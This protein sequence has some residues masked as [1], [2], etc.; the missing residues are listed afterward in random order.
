MCSCS[1]P[2]FRM[3]HARPLDACSCSP[4]C[5]CRPL[6]LPPPRRDGVSWSLR[7]VRPSGRLSHS[8]NSSRCDHGAALIAHHLLTCIREDSQMFSRLS[9]LH[10]NQITARHLAVASVFTILAIA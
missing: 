4:S 2:E 6:E 5:T 1:R 8:S 9:Q 7:V 10:S 3:L